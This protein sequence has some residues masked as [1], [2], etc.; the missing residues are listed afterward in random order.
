MGNPTKNE[1]NVLNTAWKIVKRKILKIVLLVMS[2][3]SS[4]NLIEPNDESSGPRVRAATK[5]TERITMIFLFMYEVDPS[6]DQ[7]VNVEVR[8]NI[9]Q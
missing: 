7:E 2:S 1:K 8:I 5:K 9:Q 3:K 4:P 6:F